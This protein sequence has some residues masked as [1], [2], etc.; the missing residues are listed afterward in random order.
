MLVATRGPYLGKIHSREKEHSVRS[1]KSSKSGHPY[2]MVS[3]SL[4]VQGC[5]QWY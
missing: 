2:R 5:L 4:G 1:G 3:L